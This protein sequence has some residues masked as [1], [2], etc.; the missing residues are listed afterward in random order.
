MNSEII[1]FALGA[2]CGLRGLRSSGR[3]SPGLLTSASS[4]SCFSRWASANVP[5]PKADCARYAR[6]EMRG[7]VDMQKLVG[8]EQLLAETGHGSQLVI[9]LV[10]GFT[11][12]LDLAGDELTA[13]FELL[14]R[15][16]PLIGNLPG[17]GNLLRERGRGRAMK[18]GCRIPG[19][20]RRSRE[21][22]QHNPHRPLERVAG[23]VSEA[24]GHEIDRIARFDFDPRYVAGGFAGFGRPFTREPRPAR[25]DPPAHSVA[26]F[27]RVLELSGNGDGPGAW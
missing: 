24:V 23:H 2:K 27:G 17:E 16:R 25:N 14:G 15:D 19:V 3:F 21:I 18:L 1:A 11:K 26:V 13:G 7:S 10:V 9:R 20:E 8:T 5:M 4:P 6:L 22:G 12:L